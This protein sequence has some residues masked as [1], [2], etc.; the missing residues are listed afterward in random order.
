MLLRYAY[1]IYNSTEDEMCS[2]QGLL[3]EK[4]YT[5][6]I[7][8][9]KTTWRITVVL[10]HSRAIRKIEGESGEMDVGFPEVESGWE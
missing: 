3:N 10:L 2:M 8:D 9:G 6:Q 4:Y 1:K 7:Y 5:L